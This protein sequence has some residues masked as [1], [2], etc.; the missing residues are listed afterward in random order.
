MD[1]IEATIQMRKYLE[2]QNQ[3]QPIIIGV[4]GHVD[5]KFVEE[6]KKAGMNEIYSKPLVYEVL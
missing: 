1:G 6:G 4:T 2:E 5:D 3:T